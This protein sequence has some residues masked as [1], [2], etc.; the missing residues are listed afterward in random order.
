MHNSWVARRWRGDLK[1]AGRLHWVQGLT[2][3]GPGPQVGWRRADL[4][5]L[6]RGPNAVTWNDMVTRTVIDE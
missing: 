2:G 3:K 6:V 4:I 5:K 1:G